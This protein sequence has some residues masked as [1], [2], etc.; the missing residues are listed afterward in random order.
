MNIINK[1]NQ[2]K[3]KKLEEKM[4]GRAVRYINEIENKIKNNDKSTAFEILNRAKLDVDLC[5][6]EYKKILKVYNK[7]NK[8]INIKQY[9]ERLK[10]YE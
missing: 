2:I 9:L 10:R 7:L 1:I 3:R 6:F 8:E 4:C 5:D